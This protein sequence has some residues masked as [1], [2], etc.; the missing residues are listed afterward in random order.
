MDFES[1]LQSDASSVEGALDRHLSVTALAGAGVPERLS[2]AMRY[3]VLGGGKRFRPFLTMETA[4]LFDV[5]PGVA[6]EVAAA[7]EMVHCYSLVHDDLPAMDDD[8]LRR[9]QPTVWAAFDE[10]TAILVGDALLTIAFEILTSDTLAIP[11][12]TQLVLVTQLARA[13]GPAG[14]VGGQQLDLDVGKRNVPV[15]PTLA[16]VE[17][18]QAMKT[19]ALFALAAQSGAILGSATREQLGALQ[20]YGQA[21]GL[22]FQIT[23][24]LLDV[25]GDCTRVGKGVAK[26]AD[27]GKATLVGLLGVADARQRVE[28]LTR[29]ANSA[30]SIFGAPADR[31][32]EAFEFATNRD[33]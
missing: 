33:R 3:A 5:S 31:L 10:W 29:E 1:Q 18:L 26:D 19:G 11:P 14:M 16:F 15:N 2:A 24:D 22:A 21:L 7:I 6:A 30:L 27:A 9:G 32:R 8:R 20:K 23:D 13:A 28:V 25:E 12:K 4:R 17:R